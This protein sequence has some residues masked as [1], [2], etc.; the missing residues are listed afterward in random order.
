M[1]QDTRPSGQVVLDLV[2]RLQ[3]P[4]TNLAVRIDDLPPGAADGDPVSDRF[5]DEEVTGPLTVSYG[6]AKAFYRDSLQARGMSS[7][8]GGAPVT[9]GAQVRTTYGSLPLDHVLRAGHRLRFTFSPAEGGSLP[10]YTGG[11]VELVLGEG[12]STVA[13]PVVR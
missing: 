12:G 10:A 3:G 7:P 1:A 6:Y 4:D 2:Y 8:T 9:P 11:T 5:S 13:L